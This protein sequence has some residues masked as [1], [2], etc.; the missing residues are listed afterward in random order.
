MY[1]QIL[2]NAFKEYE[3]LGGKGAT[4]LYKKKERKKENGT[5]MNQTDFFRNL[6]SKKSTNKIGENYVSL[7]P[8]VFAA[9]TFRHVL[10][11]SISLPVHADLT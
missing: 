2:C 4:G 9:L 8:S 6:K 11:L 3:H 10:P 7:S 1:V 5:E